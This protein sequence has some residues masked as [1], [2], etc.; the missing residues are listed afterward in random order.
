MSSCLHLIEDAV[1]SGAR[2]AGRAD[3]LDE[4]ERQ[5]WLKGR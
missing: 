5:M 2:N 3:G 1:D 4:F